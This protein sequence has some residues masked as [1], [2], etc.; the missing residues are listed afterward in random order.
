MPLTH[1]VVSFLLCKAIK[2]DTNCT[3][4][5]PVHVFAVYNGAKIMRDEHLNFGAVG[6]PGRWRVRLT[7][8]SSVEDQNRI[9]AMDTSVTSKINERLDDCTAR[10]FRITQV[11]DMRA[12]N[13][14][15]AFEISLDRVRIGNSASQCGD[16][17]T[18]VSIDPDNEGE[19]RRDTVNEP[20]KSAREMFDLDTNVLLD[21]SDRWCRAS[22]STF[23]G[24]RK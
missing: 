20:P 9:S 11:A 7:P 4:R 22:T 10:C 19:E 5:Y 12:W 13:I 3:I 8:M 6:F 21:G 23:L 2:Q 15:I 17:Q 16:F 18:F 14:E 24:H 1:D